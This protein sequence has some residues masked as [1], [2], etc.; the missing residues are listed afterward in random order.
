MFGGF[1]KG[2]KVLVTGVAGVKGSWLALELLEAGS[3]V[4]GMDLELPESHSNFM[5]TG[6]KEK[7]SFVQGDVT[8]LSLMQDLLKDIDYI[9]HLAAVVLVGEARRNPLE[10][11]RTNT[12]GTA[13]V[14]EAVR[15]SDSVE[16]AVFITTDKVYKSKGNEAWVETDPLVATGPYPV[17]KACAEFIIADYYRDYLHQAGKRVGIGRAG[18]VVVGGDFH[19]SQRT[20]GAGRIFVD[21]FVAL[22][23]N[24]APEL[25]TPKFTRPYTYG[26]DILTGYMTLMSRLDCEEVDGKAFNFGPH[27]QYGVENTLLATKICELWGTGPMWRSGTPRDEPFEKQ[28]LSWD[29]ARRWLAWQPAYTLYEALRDTQRWYREWSDRGKTSGEGGMYEFNKSLIREHRDAARR[30]GIWWAQEA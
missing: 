11:Y 3:Q 4:V 6:L 21:C 9:F 16:R 25:F 15:V 19:S 13:T 14:L 24:Q 10:A 29:K 26:L 17:S 20:S 18:N 2:K 30:L 7:I 1:F 5:A 12:L 8:N 22:M 28:S 23:E 27:E